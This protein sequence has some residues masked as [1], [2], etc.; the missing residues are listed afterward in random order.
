MSGAAAKIDVSVRFGSNRN[1]QASRGGYSR[2]W[3]IADHLRRS[4]LE[5]KA[6]LPIE[7]LA[8]STFVCDSAHH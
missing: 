6:L 2:C 5:K 8:R 3:T 4:I 7:V 1:Q